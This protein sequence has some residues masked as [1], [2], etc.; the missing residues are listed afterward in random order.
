MKNDNLLSFQ[1]KFSV[2]SGLSDSSL[3]FFF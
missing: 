2:P 3:G 1:F